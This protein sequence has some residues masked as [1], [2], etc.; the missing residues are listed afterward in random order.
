M[1]FR[2]SRSW[3]VSRHREYQAHLAN[4]AVGD[5]ISLAV[6]FLSDVHAAIA[7]ADRP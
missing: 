3:E 7:R 5:T 1:L 2:S 4:R 6:A